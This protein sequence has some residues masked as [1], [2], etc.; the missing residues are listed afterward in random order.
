MAK[1]LHVTIYDNDFWYE[2][3]RACANLYDMFQLEEYYPTEKD[4]PAL[5]HILSHMVYSFYQATK[6]IRHR[7]FS[8]EQKEQ[9]L[10]YFT[11]NLKFIEFENIPNWDN[12]E[13]FYIP[14]FDDANVLLR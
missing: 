10:E 8:T 1:Y 5:K 2:L 6:L 11:P 7:E 9:N 3:E 13:S 4:F 12:S 14:M